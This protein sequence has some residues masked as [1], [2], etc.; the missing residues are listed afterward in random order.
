MT[1]DAPALF[2]HGGPGL[3]A[4]A[5]RE[6]YGH[7]L[8]VHWWDQPRSVAL[9]ENPFD[10]LVNAA[11]RELWRLSAQH[12]APVKLLA[13]SFGAHVAV[14]LAARARE[15][16][17]ALLLLAPVHDV[18]DAFIRLG[19]RLSKA[20]PASQSLAR[21]LDEFRSA[22]SF[23]Q[24]TKLAGEMTTFANFIDL[25][26]SPK[27]EERRRWYVDLLVRRPL[28]DAHA[29]DAILRSFWH[30]PPPRDAIAPDLPVRIVFA[31]AD[32]LVDVE[33]ERRTWSSLLHH[34]DSVVL[35]GG[36]F[37]HLE[38]EPAGWWPRA[39]LRA[40]A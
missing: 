29:F 6:R 32:P 13:H 3:S 34:A 12:R 30:A 40:G 36:H 15:R 14:R 19:T 8:P 9:D 39:W 24:F 38:H 7:A 23:E 31:N 27:A 35:D 16:I 37:I 28:F 20:N 5:E 26:W 4:I 22:R 33:A 10:A 2:L 18:G 1:S 25:Y 21:A 17:D 11:E